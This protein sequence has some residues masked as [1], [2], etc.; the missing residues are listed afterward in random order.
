MSPFPSN[1]GLAGLP[2]RSNASLAL[3]LVTSLLAS[4]Y[5]PEVLS[6][7]PAPS[8]TDGSPLLP[9][10]REGLERARWPGRCQLIE[11][12][13]EG[14]KTRW[15]LDGAHTKE[16]LE[17]CGKWFWGEMGAAAATKKEGEQKTKRSVLSVPFAWSD[18]R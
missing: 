9:A 6:H 17:G 7:I 5:V 13:E 15:W 18:A 11:E 8:V 16:S 4:P 12:E 3:S 14:E 10:L 2:Q 1:P